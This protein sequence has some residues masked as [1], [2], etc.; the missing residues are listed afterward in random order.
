MRTITSS[1]GDPVDLIWIATTERLGFQ[2]ITTPSC[3]ASYD[4]K[5][6]IAL[7]TPDELDPDDCVAQ[8]LFHELCH[9]LIAGPGAEKLVDWGLEQDSVVEEHACHRVQAALA[10]RHGLRGFFAVTTD[11][12]PYWDALPADPL[13]D[14]GDPAVAI[15]RD[16]FERAT[17]GPWAGALDGALCATAQIA[18][19]VS[20][21]AGAGS[22]WA[23]PQVTA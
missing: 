18:A 7:S 21:Y 16:A 6:T 9:A 19:I 20:P 4:G 23:A 1:Y 8:M 10:D 15:A 17:A 5:G 12:R 2:M 11:W 13:A 14:D 3:F 22:L